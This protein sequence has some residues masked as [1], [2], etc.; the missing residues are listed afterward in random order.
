MRTNLLLS[1]A[2]AALTGPAFAADLPARMPVKAPVVAAPVFIW[3]GC[4]VGAHIGGGFGQTKLTDT[5]GFVTFAGSGPT[6]NT[7]GFLGG[8]QV[9][10]NYQFS[11]SWVV[12]AEGEFSA[13]DIK[14]D[15]SFLDAGFFP[16][17]AHAKT[18]WLT[19]A[20]ARLGYT[21]DRWLVYAKGGAA[22]AHDKFEWA[23][24]GFFDATATESRTGWT[25]GA[26]IEWAFAP[27]WSTR[28]EYDYYDFGTLTVTDSVSGFS[29][30]SKNTIHT[31]KAGV[32]Y[33][34]LGGG[35]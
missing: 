24:A 23:E 8:G 27:N 17:T 7:S 33:R 13:S 16:A 12:G 25:V 11:P 9:G 31:V 26:G 14:G 10:C 35:Y 6:I 15:S 18:D 29:V 19:S 2:I 3:T 34:F 28:L 21:W 5:T 4:Y 1:A 30:D 32:N 20:T 22:W